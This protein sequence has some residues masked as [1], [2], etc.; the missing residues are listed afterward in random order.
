MHSVCWTWRWRELEKKVSII[1]LYRN[2][3]RD[4]FYYYFVDD[5]RYHFCTSHSYLTLLTY[6]MVESYTF[7]MEWQ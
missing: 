6:L 2:Y 1:A 7:Q 3:S 5:R 4:N